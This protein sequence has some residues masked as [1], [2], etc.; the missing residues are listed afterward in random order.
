MIKLKFMPYLSKALK[1]EKGFVAVFVALAM[2]VILGMSALSIDIGSAYL[3]M[4]KMQKAVDAAVYSAGRQLPVRTDDYNAINAIKESAIYYAGL[5][6]F[7]NL[8]ASDVTLGGAV[9]GFYTNL[10]IE[11]QGSVNTSFARIFDVDSLDFTKSAMVKMSAIEQTTGLIPLGVGKEEFLS[12]VQKQLTDGVQKV[13]LK[14]TAGGGIGPFY[15]ILDFDG[16]GGQGVDFS[17]DLGPSGY[18]GVVSMNDILYKGFGAKAGISDNIYDAHA[19]PHYPACTPENYEPDCPS[20]LKIPVYTVMDSK[21]IRV[22][23]FAAFILQPRTADQKTADAIVG[24]YVR[25]LSIG[26]AGGGDVSESDFNWLQTLM[27]VE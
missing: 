11:T 13:V 27:L 5:N 4:E 26:T 16:K 23:G 3:S 6:G 22:D 9:Y 8:P 2:V 19:C 14:N 10:R 7:D 18:T 20:I 15:S 24:S 1:A 17:R 12:V 21:T 25:T